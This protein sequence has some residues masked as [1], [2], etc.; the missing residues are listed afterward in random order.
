MNLIRPKAPRFYRDVNGVVE[1]CYK[2]PVKNKKFLMD[3]GHPGTKEPTIADARELGLLPSVTT[4]LSVLAKPGLERWKLEQ[5]IHSALT[6][7]RE[8][9]EGED[10]FARRVVQDMDA[11]AAKAAEFGTRIHDAVAALLGQYIENY[12]ESIDED[13]LP[14]LEHFRHWAA[15]NIEEVHA[16]EKVVGGKHCGYAGRLDLD[17]T[18]RGV[19]RTICDV[20]TQGVKEGKEPVFYKDWLGQLSAYSCAELSGG[21]MSIVIDSRSPGPVHTKLWTFQERLEGE[22]MFHHCFELWKLMNDYEPGD[23]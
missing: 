1:A 20:K 10:A 11:Q 13:L 7:P 9:G 19:G 8:A 15:D 17:C 18:L 6:L 22:R 16:V 21:V 2:V 14:Y 12:K 5:A 3:E 4:I 23:V